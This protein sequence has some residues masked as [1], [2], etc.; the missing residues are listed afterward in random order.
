MPSPRWASQTCHCPQ[1]PNSPHLRQMAILIASGLESQRRFVHSSFDCLL[2]PMRF[3][4][5]HS[6][7][8]LLH[9]SCTRLNHRRLISSVAASS[10]TTF[11]I[12]FPGWLC[13]MCHFL[14]GLLIGYAIPKYGLDPVTERWVR[15]LCPERLAMETTSHVE[16]T[17][18]V[19]GN[20][21]TTLQGH[22]S[23]PAEPGTGGS[24]SKGAGAKLAARGEGLC[25]SSTA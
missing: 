4:L 25:S 19:T 21:I 23:M 24:F 3:V 20:N 11:I 10:W 15:F 7:S 16:E 2:R 18:Q 12:T 22:S 1:L 8:S 5:T 13:S 14:P 17:G 6:K 9:R